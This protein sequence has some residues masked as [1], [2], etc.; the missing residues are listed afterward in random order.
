MRKKIKQRL[1]QKTTHNAI[2]ID[3]LSK[4]FINCT[5]KKIRGIHKYSVVLATNGLSGLAIK[6]I[7]T[8]HLIELNKNGSLGLFTTVTTPLPSPIFIA[9]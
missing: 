9:S 2:L 6:K 3:I 1:I 7:A 8:N 5:S 4:D